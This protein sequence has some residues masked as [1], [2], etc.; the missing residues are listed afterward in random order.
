[1]IIIVESWGIILEFS[2]GIIERESDS[3][4]TS[5]ILPSNNQRRV[6]RYARASA[7]VRSEVNGSGPWIALW[8]EPDSS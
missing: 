5:W 4:R 3:I 1:M 8:K 2:F 6:P 7:N